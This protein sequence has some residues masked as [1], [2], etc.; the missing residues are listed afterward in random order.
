MNFLKKLFKKKPKTICFE[1]E[2]PEE[3]EARE[4]QTKQFLYLIALQ[5]DKQ[6][7]KKNENS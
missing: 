1:E 2:T 7:K 4:L 5:L 3:K 6:R